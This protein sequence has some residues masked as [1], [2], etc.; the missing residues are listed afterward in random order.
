MFE[1]LYLIKKE[2]NFFKGG[3]KMKETYELIQLNKINVNS[4]KYV[5]GETK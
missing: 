2:I 5:K 4:R 1:K 3:N